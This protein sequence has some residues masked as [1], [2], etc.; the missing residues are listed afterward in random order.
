MTITI[1]KWAFFLAAASVSTVQAQTATKA[2]EAP[3]ATPGKITAPVIYGRFS[4]AIESS[5]IGDAGSRL[6]LK[7]YS[8]RLGVRG[9][10]TIDED[11]NLFYGL[12]AQVLADSGATGLG[13]DLRNAYMGIK[14]KE[15]GTVVA[16]RL[17]PLVSAPLYL[18]IYTALDPVGMDTGSLQILAPSGRDTG[19]GSL[20]ARSATTPAPT[21]Q[22]SQSTQ[23]LLARAR[24]SNAVG[25]AT[26]YK[27]FDVAA[28]FV[29]DG[30]NDVVGISPNQLGETSARALEV[31]AT[32]KTE[33]WMW[34]VGFETNT[35]SADP[36]TTS[37]RFGDRFQFVTSVKLG[38]IRYGATFARNTVET[39]RAG[40]D[41]S[42]N[43]FALAAK[44]PVMSGKAHVIANY[45]IRDLFG[46]DNSTPTAAGVPKPLA[47]PG[48]K[49]KQL[50][51]GLHYDINPSTMSYAVYNLTDGS[52]KASQDE[53]TVI[54]AGLRH[55]F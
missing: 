30:P 21:G 12:E 50:A 44:M 42:G 26:Q 13:G 16:G 41:K 7:S 34:G 15:W 10:Q 22:L 28:R 1:K 46:T 25:Y 9:E 2:D 20:L 8:S 5:S 45:A 47:T 37:S 38:S 6:A 11:M 53:L 52:N 36:S 40:A 32:K 14:S 17:D 27:G 55:N 43:E 54:A 35:Y 3:A 51:V 49:R 33:N 23:T 24:V 29:S 18:Q 48:A 19:T 4:A 39:R 31:A